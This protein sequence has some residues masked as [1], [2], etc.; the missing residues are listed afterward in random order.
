[1]SLEY[2]END[3][4]DDMHGLNRYQYYPPWI[5]TEQARLCKPTDMKHTGK[6]EARTIYSFIATTKLGSFASLRHEP[7]SW[8]MFLSGKHRLRTTR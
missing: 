7:P 1:M 6:R 4:M 2:H 3:P 5:T 8:R